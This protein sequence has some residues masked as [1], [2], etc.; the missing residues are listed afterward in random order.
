MFLCKCDCGNEKTIQAQSLLGGVSESCGCLRREMVA[1]KN[2]RHGESVR[3]NVTTEYNTWL[4]MI[5]RC[6]N[7]NHPNY[8]RYGGRGITVCDRWLNSFKFF[9]KDMGRKPSPEYTIERIDNDLGYSPA[10]CQWATRLEQAQNR[11]K[12]ERRAVLD[13]PRPKTYIGK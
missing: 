13:T 10:N 6:T 7:P 3:G 8:D 12:P 9:L 4:I 11:H 2:K 1:E 5:Q